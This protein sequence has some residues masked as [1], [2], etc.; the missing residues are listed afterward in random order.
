MKDLEI[1]DYDNVEKI[2]S[3]P[4][5]T[6]KK[7]K[8]YLNKVIH[9]ANL[10]RNQLKGYKTR[11]T[12]PYKKGEIGEAQRA[13]ENKGIDDARIVL[14]QYIKYYETK[15][16]GKKGMR[17]RGGNVMFFNNPKTLLKKLEL[18]I[19]NLLIKL[20]MQNCISNIFIQFNY[21]TYGTRN[22]FIL[23]FG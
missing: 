10:R 3:Q 9:N 17:K 4:E 8:S 19:E 23:L 2:I 1:T 18:I 14:N 11:V 6:R 20:N 21:I 13:Q 15:I 5:I 22:S 7:I 12:N 16:E